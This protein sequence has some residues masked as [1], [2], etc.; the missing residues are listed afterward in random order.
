MNKMEQVKAAISPLVQVLI[1]CFFLIVTFSK[2]DQIKKEIII[3]LLN[4]HILS[5]M[6]NT[7]EVINDGNQLYILRT[8]KEREKITKIL[9][10]FQILSFKF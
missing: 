3:T 6:G 2:T 4:C 5:L 7:S 10:V 8:K 1:S 9:Q